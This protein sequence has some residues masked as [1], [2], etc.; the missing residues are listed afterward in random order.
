[1][2]RRHM[3]KG[4]AFMFTG[5]IETIGIV[6]GIMPKDDVWQLDIEAPKIARELRTGDSVSVSGACSTVTRSDAVAFSV[7]LM[8][9]TRN[10]TKLG[11]L[12]NGSRVNLERA[13][14]LDS[15]LDGHIVSGHIDGLAVVRKIEIYPKTR[16]YFFSAG[17]EILSGIVPK[18][19]VAVDG[20][21]LTVIDV[22]AEAFSVGVIP[23]TISETT[24][25]DLKEGE[26]VNIETDMIG[27]YITKFLNAG[28]PNTGAGREAATQLTWDKLV[29]YG[30]A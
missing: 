30:W 14:R 25:S 4:G 21:S 8:E 15:R 29:K 9:E 28:F 16:K 26:A 2:Q 20:I 11:S 13:M 5:L 27:K 23:T 1:M 19:S 3:D 22:D 6:S 18:G 17:L 10:R 7:E 24:L 12:K